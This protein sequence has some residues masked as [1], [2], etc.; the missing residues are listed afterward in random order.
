MP[1]LLCQV[2][3]VVDAWPSFTAVP[4]SRQASLIQRASTRVINHCR[5]PG[6][7]QNSFDE[8]HDGRN[9][10]RIWLRQRPVIAVSNVIING[11]A[12]DNTFGSGWHFRG[13]TGELIRGNG[14]DDTRFVPWFPAGQQNI[15][16]VYS[17]GFVA[18]PDPVVEA[19]CWTVKWMY[20]QGKISGVFR[21]ESIGDYSY[22]LSDKNLDQDLPPHIAA[23]LVDYVQDD[24][25]L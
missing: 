3:D 9:L 7:L 23:M 13:D 1:E 15:E 5:R 18:V 19:A 20:D 10:P 21:S 22:T 12:L 16:V 25:P 11:D 17:A 24:G 2:S 14:Q 8:F 6:F 4:A